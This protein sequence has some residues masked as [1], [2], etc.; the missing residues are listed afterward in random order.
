MRE[1]VGNVFHGSVRQA[2]AADTD[3][4]VKLGKQ[5]FHEAFS[6]VTAPDDMKAYIESTFTETQIRNQV[7]DGRSLF[8]IA[9]MDSVPAGYAYSYPNSPPEFIKAEAAIQLVRL[10]L[11][12]QYYGRSVGDALMRFSIDQSSSRGYKT[13]WL[14]SWE[15][16]DRANA[17]Y[18]RWRFKVVGRQKFTVGS[19]IQ[20]DFI[21]SRKI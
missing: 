10:Y 5:A 4:L 7:E 14:S 19:D 11:R 2:T 1:K 8:F 21:L 13:I 17:F 18:K 15:L 9:E 16:N 12:K 6:K 3:L 20:N